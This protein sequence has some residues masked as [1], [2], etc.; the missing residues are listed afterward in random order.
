MAAECSIS[1]SA[2]ASRCSTVA[3]ALARSRTAAWP[4]VFAVTPWTVPPSGGCC[5]QQASSCDCCRQPRTGLAQR[6]HRVVQPCRR[7]PQQRQRRNSPHPFLRRRLISLP[8]GRTACAVQRVMCQARR[9]NYA[10]HVSLVAAVCCEAEPGSSA[11]C[12]A[13]Q[14]PARHGRPESAPRHT[15]TPRDPCAC[16]VRPLPLPTAASPTYLVLPLEGRCCYHADAVWGMGRTQT[17][18]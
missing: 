14:S 9:R 1:P 18:A 12:H 2:S 17:A 5:V 6:R 13:P 3:R 8:T 4:A 7:G 15:H 11:R 16:V 10:Q